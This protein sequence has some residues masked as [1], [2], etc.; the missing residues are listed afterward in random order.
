M[1][2]KLCD[3]ALPSFTKLCRLGSG[4]YS[5]VDM[6]YAEKC[7]EYEKHVPLNRKIARKR[8]CKEDEFRSYVTECYIAANFI[9]DNL[10]PV[11]SIG[12]YP[13]NYLLMEIHMESHPDKLPCNLNMENR[14]DLCHQLLDVLTFL[15]ENGVYHWDVKYDN[16]V[17]R[18]DNGEYHLYLIDFGLV[19]FDLSDDYLPDLRPTV[20][21]VWVYYNEGFYFDSSWRRKYRS[22]QLYSYSI[23]IALIKLL[24][25]SFSTDFECSTTEDVA[26]SEQIIKDRLSSLETL[27]L[28]AQ[29]VELIRDLVG[30]SVINLIDRCQTNFQLRVSNSGRVSDKLARQRSSYLKC[31]TYQLDDSKSVFEELIH[32]SDNKVRFRQLCSYF[33]RHPLK[34]IAKKWDEYIERDFVTG[35][36]TELCLIEF[37]AAIIVERHFCVNLIKYSLMRDVM[38]RKVISL[39]LI[40]LNFDVSF[41]DYF[42]R[43]DE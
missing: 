6:C 10:V 22:Y 16:L 21:P 8:I 43:K 27:I 32:G 3:R 17:F 9:H 33:S 4:S 20:V 7:E 1:F 37:P 19:E 38:A 42:R 39:W 2:P 11:Y 13:V 15:E 26:V 31:G 34:S 28:D 14:I 5:E 23:G 25:P 30:M 41:F 29:L 12:I 35:G 24:D 36:T 40:K 18:N